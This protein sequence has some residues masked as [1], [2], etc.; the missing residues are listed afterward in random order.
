[1]PKEGKVDL[2]KV[3]AI[4]DYTTQT[5]EG[6]A[7]SIVTSSISEQNHHF[8]VSQKKLRRVKEGMVQFYHCEG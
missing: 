6:E 4:R 8:T 2:A 1:M 5:K 3:S 7:A